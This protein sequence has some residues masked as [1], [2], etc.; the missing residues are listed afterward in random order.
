MLPREQFI[1]TTAHKKCFT[2]SAWS[3]PL[4]ICYRANYTWLL[5]VT[6]KKSEC[7]KQAGFTHQMKSQM[8][9]QNKIPYIT[10][11]SHVGISM[12]HPAKVQSKSPSKSEIK[13]KLIQNSTKK[14]RYSTQYSHVVTDRSTDW[15]VTS[16]TLEIGRDP[17]LSGA[18]GR[19]TD[20]LCTITPYVRVKL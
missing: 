1:K 7:A 3:I 8:K 2:P 11:Y 17:V 5:L 6:L 13:I 15:A 4:P 18:Y 20:I 9:T 14:M 12:P 16:L 19:N 10:Y